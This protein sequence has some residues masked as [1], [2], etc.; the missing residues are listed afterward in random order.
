MKLD[1]EVEA[2]PAVKNYYKGI[3]AEVEKQLSVAEKAKSKGFDISSGIESKPVADLAD[4]AETIIGPVGIAKRYREVFAEKKGDRLETIFQIF[5]EI[6]EQR[7][8]KI[9]DEGKRV[10]QAIKTG[11]VLNTEGGRK[12]VHRHLLCRAHKGSRWNKPSPAP[13]SGRLREKPFRD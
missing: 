6:I 11:L 7:W 8:C 12:Q 4:R 5:K 2:K 10:E 1:I 3:V 13:H 9:E